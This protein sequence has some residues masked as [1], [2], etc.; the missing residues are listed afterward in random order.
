VDW[1]QVEV[2]VLEADTENLPSAMHGIPTGRN[3][4]QEL[5]TCDKGG[6]L[7][8][9]DLHAGGHCEAGAIFERT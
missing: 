9:I 4:G 2:L 6:I 8:A 1:P 5:A 3:D 7:R